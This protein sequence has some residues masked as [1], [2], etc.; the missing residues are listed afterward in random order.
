VLLGAVVG[1]LD[2]SE[3]AIEFGAG[4]GVLVGEPDDVLDGM[5]LGSAVGS[6]E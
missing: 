1:S 6:A 3:L 4:L 5:L 2:G